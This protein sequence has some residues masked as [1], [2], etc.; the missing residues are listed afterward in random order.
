MNTIH[1]QY[2]IC[3]SRQRRKLVVFL[4]LFIFSFASHSN[5][6]AHT[7]SPSAPT[8][9]A[10]PASFI[11]TTPCADCAGIKQILTLRS[12]GLYFLRRQYLGKKNSSYSEHGVWTV[13]TSG[14]KLTLHNGNTVTQQVM[15]TNAGN[16]RLLT[17][18]G[19][20]LDTSANVDLSRMA[21]VEP[22]D[23]ASQWRGEF[24]YME[25]VPTFTD[26]VS[27]LHWSIA[28]SADFSTIKRKYL[29]VHKPLLINFSGRLAKFPA[30]QSS[31]QEQL[32]IGK[33]HSVEKGVS[34]GKTPVDEISTRITSGSKNPSIAT[35]ITSTSLK[36]TYWKLIELNGN[37]INMPSTQIRNIRI[38][39]FGTDSRMMGYGGCNQISGNYEQEGSALHFKKMSNMMRTCE[40]PFMEIESQILKKLLNTVTVYRIEDNHLIFL[41]SDHVLARFEAINI[42]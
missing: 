16:L 10:L 35:K 22:M 37:E 41:T 27:G 19:E 31:P 39:L 4:L 11:G 23:K 13:D 1:T 33:V 7:N 24:Q 2:N 15:V 40:S 20:S 26:C 28:M 17:Q 34:C 9:I 14:K 29:E 42:K 3:S 18:S 36:D 38:K 6:H 5:L 8:G 30:K 21:F 25:G 32:V 12:D